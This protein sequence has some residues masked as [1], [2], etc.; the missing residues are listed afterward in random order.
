MLTRLP[1]LRDPRIG[2]ALLLGAGVLLA[3]CSTPGMNARR[4]PPGSTP[5][6]AATPGQIEK[7]MQYLQHAFLTDA[8]LARLRRAA[9]ELAPSAEPGVRPIYALEFPQRAPDGSSYRLHVT[10]RDRLA[11]LYISRGTAGWYTV[12][13]PL[14]LWQCLHNT[15]SR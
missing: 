8:C 6:P 11:Y 3:G 9:P 2:G 10:E 1:A 7:E 13:G 5:P 15:L 4:I 12:R 14:P